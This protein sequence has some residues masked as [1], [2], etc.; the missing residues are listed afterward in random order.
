MLPTIAWENESVIM[1]DQRKLPWKEE[2]LSCR[3]V[4]QVAQAI[5]KMV[6]RG[7]PAI[8]LAAAYGLALGV[9]NLKT[10]KNLDRVFASFYQRLW[11][12]RPTARNLFWALERMKKIYE[13]NKNLG[14]NRLKNILLEEAKAIEE[15]DLKTNKEIG[16]NG[17]ELVPAEAT[18]LTHCNAGAL[19]TA[20]Y[21]TALGVI[22]AAWARGK[23]IKVLADET[24]PFLQGARLTCWELTRDGIPTTLI[25]DSMAGWL[26]RRGEVSLVIVGADRIALNG[27]TANKIGTYSLAVLAKENNIPFYVAAPLS[28][29]DFNLK[30]G[31]NIPIE[32]RHPDEVR[33]VGGHLITLP[34]IPVKNPAFDVTPARL[35]TAIITE[36]GIIR[37][38]YGKNILRLRK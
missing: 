7:A 22:R 32:E 26:M 37:P 8:G 21:G 36:K 23:K 38:P 4:E 12:T 9:R 33:K 11:R 3:T 6:I 5:E 1:V 17:Q 18:I 15:E 31:E 29:F 20:G 34:E 25:A 35:I 16:E 19:A 24:R 10:E 2:Y 13:E 14:L 28:T 27:D 30:S